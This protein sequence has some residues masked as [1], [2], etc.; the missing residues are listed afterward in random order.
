MKF[1]E[2]WKAGGRREGAAAPVPLLVLLLLLPL[3]G[4]AAPGAGSTQPL[5]NSRV[6]TSNRALGRVRGVGE[7]AW[8][9]NKG[10]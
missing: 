5:E 9:A 10:E 3:L 1:K 6:P 2:V 7:V 8:R 4:L